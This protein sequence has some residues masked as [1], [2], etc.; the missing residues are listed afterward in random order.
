M[1]LQS[2]WVIHSRRHLSIFDVNAMMRSSHAMRRLMQSNALWQCYY[3]RE[4]ED[5]P[6]GLGTRDDYDDEE[7]D[8]CPPAR[9]LLD[10]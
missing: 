4:W 2:W 10:Q 3:I 9:D 1:I 8:A 7:Y 6:Y 5:L